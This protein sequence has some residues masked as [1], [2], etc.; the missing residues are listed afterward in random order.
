MELSRP[1]MTTL[2]IIHSTPKI[3][4]LQLFEDGHCVGTAKVVGHYLDDIAV[5]PEYRHRGHGRRLL[6]ACQGAG[7]DRAVAVS[8]E[9]RHLLAG[10]GWNSANGCRFEA[11]ERLAA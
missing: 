5:Y 9:G 4:C 6:R 11:P 8:E 3:V 7:A 2:K 1:I 10:A